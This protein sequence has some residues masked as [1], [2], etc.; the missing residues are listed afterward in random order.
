MGHSKALTHNTART[1]TILQKLQLLDI[2]AL[3]KLPHSQC[4][5]HRPTLDLLLCIPVLHSGD[6][7]GKYS[8]LDTV[9]HL[10][11]TTQPGLQLAL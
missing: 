5:Y 9:E 8:Q 2:K 4:S 10:G 11:V 1:V 7:A 3:R 6:S